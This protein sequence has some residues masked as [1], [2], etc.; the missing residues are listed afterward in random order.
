VSPDEARLALQALIR[1]DDL[2]PEA[3]VVLFSE[4]AEYYKSLVA[5]PPETVEAMPDEQYIRNVV[6]ILFR[7]R[8]AE[9]KPKEL[10]EPQA[11][12]VA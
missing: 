6:D 9:A 2:D 3:R 5:F 4:L 11:A 1:R 7:T 8:G 10:K 12:G